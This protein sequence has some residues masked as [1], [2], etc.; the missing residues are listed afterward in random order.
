MALLIQEAL[1]ANN[2]DASPGCYSPEYAEILLKA[3]GPIGREVYLTR[4]LPMD[5]IYPGLF[6]VTYT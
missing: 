3:I 4:Q 6:A 5:F 2:S 1:Y